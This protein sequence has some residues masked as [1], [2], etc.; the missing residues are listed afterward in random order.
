MSVTMTA[1]PGNSGSPPDETTISG[2]DSAEFPPVMPFP[3]RLIGNY[4]LKT[5]VFIALNGNL[6]SGE[7]PKSH[8]N[9]FFRAT[10][11]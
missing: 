1:P 2:R 4:T 10:A 3:K 5:G 9:L 8:R 7:C 6:V 11:V